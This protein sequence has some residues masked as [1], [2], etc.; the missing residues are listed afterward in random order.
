MDF[1]YD[2]FQR[3]SNGAFYQGSAILSQETIAEAKVA[4]RELREY[5]ELRS[6][7]FDSDLNTSVSNLCWLCNEPLDAFF[8]R[9]TSS[10][11]KYAPFRE[12]LSERVSAIEI[13]MRE[14]LTKGK[15]E[16]DI[17]RDVLLG[18]Q[19]EG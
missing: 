14:R 15:H 8:P 13:Q 7:F 11:E 2:V 19:S 1:R 4:L 10:V 5:C 3:T 6:P 12:E 9:D 18:R 16:G 17:S